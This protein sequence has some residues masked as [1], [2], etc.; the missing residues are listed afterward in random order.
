MLLRPTR[1]A[2]DFSYSLFTPKF[3]SLSGRGTEFDGDNKMF[4]EAETISAAGEVATVA[5]N[6]DSISDDTVPTT[7]NN[8]SVKG[9]AV[10]MTGDI[11]STNGET[12]SRS[13][14]ATSVTSDTVSGED[15]VSSAAEEMI[16]IKGDSICG[17]D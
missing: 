7:L 10:S 4:A 12:V 9:D 11:I 5:T 8:V 17:T 14:D 15:D 13:G 3:S 1:Q 6:V 16:S 2:A